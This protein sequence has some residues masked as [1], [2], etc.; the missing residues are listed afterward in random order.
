ML[1]FLLDGV[2][3][4]VANDEYQ[5]SLLEVS[6]IIVISSVK[7]FCFEVKLIVFNSAGAGTLREDYKNIL[8]AIYFL[9]CSYFK[10]SSD[11]VIMEVK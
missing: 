8:A 2:K 3:V 4:Q 6:N 10:T 5:G 11:Q 9:K 7:L 1:E